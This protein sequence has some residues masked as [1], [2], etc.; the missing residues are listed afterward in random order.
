MDNGITPKSI[1][2]ILQCANVKT[3]ASL[4][5]FVLL[6]QRSP[7]KPFKINFSMFSG[8]NH[9]KNNISLSTSQTGSHTINKTTSSNVDF[10]KIKHGK[11]WN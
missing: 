2:D 1:F 10:P 5:P 4:F 6:L 7:G 11:V 8:T 3:W 9:D